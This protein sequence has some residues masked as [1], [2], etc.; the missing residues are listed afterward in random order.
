MSVDSS[1]AAKTRKLEIE[2]ISNDF[3]HNIIMYSEQ[4][5]ANTFIGQPPSLAYAF[6][7][8]NT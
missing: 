7:L 4:I 8:Q 6:L 3:Y 5:K 2:G 1:G